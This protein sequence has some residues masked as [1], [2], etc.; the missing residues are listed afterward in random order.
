MQSYQANWFLSV[1]HFNKI[2]HF[3]EVHFEH[4]IFFLKRREVKILE[5]STEQI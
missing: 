2:F 4:H 3:I 5:S 1:N